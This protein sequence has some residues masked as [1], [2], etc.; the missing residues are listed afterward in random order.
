MISIFIFIKIWGWK[1][2]TVS[3]SWIPIT[4]TTSESNDDILPIRQGQ[5]KV[6]AMA[7]E[8]LCSHPIK[9]SWERELVFL[10]L[11]IMLPWRNNNRFSSSLHTSRILLIAFLFVSIYWRHFSSQINSILIFFPNRKTILQFLFYMRL[12]KLS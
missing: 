12:K 7:R 6:I 3:S 4:R 5:E 1:L 8:F 11:P 2:L 9:T 10:L